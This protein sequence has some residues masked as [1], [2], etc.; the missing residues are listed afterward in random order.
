M[1]YYK[2]LKRKEEDYKGGIYTYDD[3]HN[4][5]EAKQLSNEITNF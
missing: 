4:K 3:Q 1:G 5:I 2:H